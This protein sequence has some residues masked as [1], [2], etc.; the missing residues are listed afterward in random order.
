[1][2]FN[3][4]TFTELLE[5]FTLLLKHL[6]W[7][8]TIRQRLPNKNIADLSALMVLRE[9]IL[10]VWCK[11]MNFV[12]PST[13]TI[14]YS[15]ESYLESRGLLEE[16]P[17]H[18]SSGGRRR[19]AAQPAATGKPWLSVVNALSEQINQLREEVR[20]SKCDHRSR[21]LRNNYIEYL[22][23]ITCRMYICLIIWNTYNELWQQ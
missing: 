19:A 1:M 17:A 10:R 14:T 13:K 21:Y 11:Y 9:S 2:N 16:R 22:S 5:F 8:A 18:T 3:P 7:S 6:P 4:I 12:K 15:L 20:A 23:R